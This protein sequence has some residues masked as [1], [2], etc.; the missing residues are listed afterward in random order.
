MSLLRI[1]TLIP[2]ASPPGA[3]QPMHWAQWG[4]GEGYQ[5]GADYVGVIAALIAAGAEL[6]ESAEGSEAVKALLRCHGVPD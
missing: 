6:P 3:S 1:L 4:S 2:P 5:P